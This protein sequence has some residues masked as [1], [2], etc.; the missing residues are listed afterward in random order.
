MELKVSN[1]AEM[2]K[3]LLPLLSGEGSISGGGDNS[4]NDG[5]YDD[6]NH[7]NSDN[8]SSSNSKT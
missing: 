3:T 7:H 4:N 2:T 1:A 8:N 5:D 6:N